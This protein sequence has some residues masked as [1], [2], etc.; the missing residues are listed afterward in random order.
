LAS[1]DGA[2][3][4]L[5]KI[6][7]ASIGSI[8]TP[9]Q[10]SFVSDVVEIVPYDTSTSI[11]PAQKVVEKVVEAASPAPSASTSVSFPALEMPSVELPSIEMPSIEVPSIEGLDLPLPVL[12]GIA[13]AVLVAVAVGVSGGS[14]GASQGETSST[15][16]GGITFSSSSMLSDPT[17][18][19]IPYDAAAML[20]YEEAGNPGDFES[21]K[22]KYVADTVAMVKAKQKAKA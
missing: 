3:S 16:S 8:P 19:S 15:S 20:A 18:L 12:G 6:D 22:K 11:E 7:G 5:N 21:F 4:L 9:P 1:F 10:P 13:I 17:D 2:D 14:E